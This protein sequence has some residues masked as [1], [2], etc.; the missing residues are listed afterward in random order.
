MYREKRK[1]TRPVTSAGNG[2]SSPCH[3]LSSLPCCLHRVTHTHTLPQEMGGAHGPCGGTGLP[4]FFVP[5]RRLQWRLAR[6]FVVVCSGPS[7]AAQR[8]AASTLAASG[9]GLSVTV[10]YSGPFV[11]S[12][13]VL[14]LITFTE[15]RPTLPGMP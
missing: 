12:R 14:R 2:L 11:V 3:R 4:S 7:R 9:P 5:L 13:P 15:W 10:S 8:A 6:Q 1:K